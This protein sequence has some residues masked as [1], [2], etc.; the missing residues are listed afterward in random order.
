[1]ASFFIVS[2]LLIGSIGF[3]YMIKNILSYIAESIEI[4][5]PERMVDFTGFIPH[6]K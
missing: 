3:G 1:M 5:L 4:N 6:Q 2:I